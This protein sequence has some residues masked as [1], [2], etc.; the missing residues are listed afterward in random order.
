MT[1]IQAQ[2]YGGG[3]Q[4]VALA[5]LNATGRVDD[6][7]RF[8]IFA[9]PGSEEPGTYQHLEITGLY[10]SRGTGDRLGACASA[11]QDGCYTFAAGGTGCQFSYYIS[12]RRINSSPPPTTS[13]KVYS[14][15]FRKTC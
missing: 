2:S 9:D 11:Y 4:S 12:L 6:P 15:E 13:S 7:A 3:V 8:A 14:A 1:L 5:I 10:T